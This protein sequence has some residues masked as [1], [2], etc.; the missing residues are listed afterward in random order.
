[1]SL[2]TPTAGSASGQFALPPVPTRCWSVEEY[3]TMLRAGILT[4]NDSIELLDGWLVSKRIKNPPHRIATRRAR[5]ALERV[6]SEGWY[7]DP[8]EPITLSA[9]EP[10]P[11][12]AL[13][14]GDY[15]PDDEVALIV[16]GV[17]KARIRVKEFFGDR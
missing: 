2:W 15:S 5:R 7:V 16:E 8:Q 17:E 3:H 9:S 6:A 10:E 11:D 14:R 1:M 13:I 12:G 4:E